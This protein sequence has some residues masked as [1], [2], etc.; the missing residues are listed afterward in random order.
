MSDTT[1]EILKLKRLVEDLDAMRGKG[2]SMIT[3]IVP[4]N[5]QIP[6]CRQMLIDER[7]TATNIKSRVNRDSVL[8]A[9]TLALTELDKF[10]HKAPDNGLVC[11]VG[12]DVIVNEKTGEI[13]KVNI[14]FEPVKPVKNKRYI[15]D[16]VFHT[17]DLHKLLTDDAAY[18]FIIVDGSQ[19][20]FGLVKGNDKR[21]L[22]RFTVCLLSKTRRGGQSALR[23]SRIRD[24][25]RHNY[26]RKVA[27]SAANIFIQ[28]NRVNVKGLIV[29]GS[30]NMKDMLIESQLFDPRLSAV[31]IQKI[32]VSYGGENGFNQAIDMTK[33]SLGDIRLTEERKLLSEY[34]SQISQNTN[35]YCYCLQETMKAL[36]MGCVKTLI[37]WD[38]LRNYR[39]IL[40]TQKDGLTQQEI[41]Y[42]VLDDPMNILAKYNDNDKARVVKQE[43]L[44]D[45][46]M[47]EYDNFG[48]ELKIVSKNTPEGTQFVQGFSGIGG[49]L[50][51]AVDMTEFDE[52]NENMDNIDDENDL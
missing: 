12:N 39:Y 21:V 41:I 1:I 16:S 5:Y 45:W 34:F 6:L 7:G 42:S 32:V 20:L 52:D 44:S 27:E 51:Y 23:F 3:L 29:A 37:I 18:G 43:L 11:F 35:K 15:C 49:L 25:Q 33:E 19:C 28:D 26:I 4:P 13:K 40:E 14:C 47:K 30:A 46:L 24:E 9:I 31:M 36:E 38:Q 10:K 2:T 8:D 22:D 50:R 17:E 48:I